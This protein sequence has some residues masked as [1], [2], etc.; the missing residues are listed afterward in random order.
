MQPILLQAATELHRSEEKAVEALLFLYDEGVP[1]STAVFA[2]D[3]ETTGLKGCVVQLGVVGLDGVGTQ[4]MCYSPLMQISP[5]FAME[6]GALAVHGLDETLLA[7]HGAS[8]NK[9]LAELGRIAAIAERRRIPIVMHNKAFDVGAIARTAQAAGTQNP[10]QTAQVQCT[11]QLGRCVT[12][13]LEGKSR[14]PK[15]VWLYETLCGPL[16]TGAARN[17]HDATFDARLTASAYLAGKT[18]NYW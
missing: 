10:L 3:T 5:G 6:E 16:P 17:L 7:T 14:A 13:Q 1:L 2:V 9:A 15:N 8:P 18:Q 11:M 12:K 4:T